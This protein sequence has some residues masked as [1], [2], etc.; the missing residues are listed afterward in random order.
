MRSASRPPS[1]AA[2]RSDAQASAS[3]EAWQMMSKLGS[4]GGPVMRDVVSPEIELVPDSLTGEQLRETPRALE[5]A[6][7]V[8]PLAL[9]A[10]DQQADAGLQPAEVV[11]VQMRDVVHR[12]LEV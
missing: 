1:P 8:L 2:A 10:D 11:A 5:R 3:D 6:G 7:R 4:P 12:V 9:P